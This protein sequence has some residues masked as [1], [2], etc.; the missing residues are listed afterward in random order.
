M[1]E[2][3]E[4]LLGR[5]G[6]RAAQRPAFMAWVLSQYM[7]GQ[8]IS[9]SDLSA[10]LGCTEQALTRLSLCLR[11]RSKQ[12]ADDIERITSILRVNGLALVRIVR[13]VEAV[14]AMSGPGVTEHG[15]LM[16]ARKRPRNDSAKVDDDP[17]S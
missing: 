13:R 1:K 2:Q 8:N 4:Q 15:T 5:A 16:A 12:F 17:S 3:K 6:A 10:E 14:E 11:P 9:R 7:A